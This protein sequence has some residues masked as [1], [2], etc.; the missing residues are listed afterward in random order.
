MAKKEL[1]IQDGINKDRYTNEARD[2]DTQLQNMLRP[3]LEMYAR[4][5]YSIR[6]IAH[7]ASTAIWD[8]ECSWMIST[9][10]YKK[11]NAVEDDE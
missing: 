3:I 1:F 5:G 7:I 4:E 10:A 6:D 8:I 9:P 2:I 11:L